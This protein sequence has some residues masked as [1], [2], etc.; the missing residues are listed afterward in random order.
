MKVYS[1]MGPGFEE[2]IYQQCLAIEFERADL[3]YSENEEHSIYYDG[4]E[5]GMRRADF[6]VENKVVVEVQALTSLPEEYLVRAKHY[7]MAY[8]LPLGLLVNFGSY[9]LQHKLV[10]NP[11]YYPRENGIQSKSY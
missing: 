9:S 1:T 7:T 3:N 5:V 4:I 6:I 11:K 10:F 2:A 8:D